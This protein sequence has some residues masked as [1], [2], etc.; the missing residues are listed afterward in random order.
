MRR[1]VSPSVAAVAAAA[2]HVVACSSSSD[3]PSP[4]GADAAGGA[5]ASSDESGIHD[6]DSGSGTEAERPSPADAAVE[7]TPA[8]DET[9]A[10]S[11]IATWPL[12]DPT[13][14][15]RPSSQ[16]Y[17]ATS[18]EV[19]IDKVTHLV[20]Q[21][22]I[23]A[24]KRGWADAKT[25]CA[26][27]SL[28]GHDDW[29]LPTRME[30]VSIVDSTKDSPAIDPTAFPATPSEWF[31]TSSPLAA[32]P[33]FAW[34]VYFETGFT[35]FI[36]KDSA[37]RARCVRSEA[38]VAPGAH[39]AVADGTVRDAY[40][41]LT[42]QQTTDG[43]MRPWAGSRAY[44][45]A[46]PLAG[47]G[48]RLPGMKELQSLVDETRASPSIDPT[49]FPDTPAEPFWTTTPALQFPGSAWRVSFENGYTYDANETYLYHA[50]CVR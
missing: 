35:N 46:L 32:D 50:R 11:L 25:Y 29:R 10:P 47:G 33:A 37:Y 9:P 4:N 40:T 15:G 6:R 23:D 5:D 16:S 14:T 31:W 44:C 21:R 19:V 20:W 27:L 36:E 43:V 18:P 17:D 39:Y 8:C 12:P 7:G 1:V 28:A 49:A 30:L 34:Y 42:W 2:L 24:G 38:P 26:C 22:Q 45:E 48:W 41:G 3:T 13:T